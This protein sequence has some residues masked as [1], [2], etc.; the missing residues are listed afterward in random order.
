VPKEKDE[1]CNEVLQVQNEQV[2]YKLQGL[3]S[4]I[5]FIILFCILFI[6]FV[7]NPDD[8]KVLP[9]EPTDLRDPILEFVKNPDDNKVLPPEPTDLRD[10][11]NPDDNKVLP[12]EPTDLQDRILELL[13]K[14]KKQI[15]ER[16]PE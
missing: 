4:R 10:R 14:L 3:F 13:Q 1:D 6:E 16:R 9:S 11:K 5:S 8:N 12:P 15:E 2:P 7:K